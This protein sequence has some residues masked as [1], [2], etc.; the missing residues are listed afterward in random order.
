M[1]NNLKNAKVKK[2]APIKCAIHVIHLF[3]PE[4]NDVNAVRGIKNPKMRINGQYVLML[5]PVDLSWIAPSVT[6]E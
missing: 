2:N 5:K 4:P 6:S 1:S 3:D